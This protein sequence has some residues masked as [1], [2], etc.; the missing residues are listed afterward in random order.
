MD[1]IYE[2][3]FFFIVGH[4]RGW[5]FSSID[6]LTKFKRSQADN[7]LSTLVKE[8]QIRRISRGLYDYPKYSDLLQK[9]LSPDIEQIANAIARKFNWRIMISG[10]SALN[11]LGVSTQVPGKYSFLSDGPNR[12][13]RIMENIEITF[14]KAALKNSGFKYRQSAL[15]VQALKALGKERVSLEVIETIRKH[16]DP[17]MYTKILKD[18]QTSTAWIYEYIKE[19]CKEE[20]NKSE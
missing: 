5:V 14:K 19:I 11:I 12:A 13:Y 6:L 17:K 20:G 7:I 10:E 2:K 1:S 9:E 8:N 16:I 18:S 15:I 4:G 3:A